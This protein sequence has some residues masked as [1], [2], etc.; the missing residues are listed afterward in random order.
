MRT[1]NV[2]KNMKAGKMSYGCQL[3][4]PDLKAIELLGMLG[5]DF[6]NIVR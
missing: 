2:I 6:V 4:S 5:F 1:N 3:S